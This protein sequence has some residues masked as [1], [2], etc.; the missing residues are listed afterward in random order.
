MVIRKRRKQA[1]W[2]FERRVEYLNAQL[3]KLRELVQ[4]QNGDFNFEALKDFLETRGR[5]RELENIRKH[6]QDW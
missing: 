6:A 5:L 2:Y 3:G 4:P 1:E